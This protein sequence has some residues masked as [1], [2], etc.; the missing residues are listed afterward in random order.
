MSGSSKFAVCLI[1]LI[2][3][4]CETNVGGSEPDVDAQADSSDAAS[5]LDTVAACGTTALAPPSVR[6]GGGFAV[7]IDVERLAAAVTFRVAERRSFVQSRLTF[8]LGQASGFPVFDLRQTPVALQ[9]DGETLETNLLERVDFASTDTGGV[10]VLNRALDSCSRHELLV[11]YDLDSGSDGNALPHWAQGVFWTSAF[12][13]LIPGMYIERW[14]PAGLIHDNFEFEMEVMVEGGDDHTFLAN[15]PI[16]TLRFNHWRAR[17]GA[18]DSST[19]LW[20]LS[21]SQHIQRWPDAS[22]AVDLYY[23]AGLFGSE[24]EDWLAIAHEAFGDFTVRFGVHAG[25]EVPYL[26]IVDPFG[27]PSDGMEYANGAVVGRPTRDILRH[28]IL[29]A[30]LGRSL[31]P[32][33]HI[34]SWWD[35]GAA[36]FFSADESANLAVTQEPLDPFDPDAVPIASSDAWV[37]NSPFTAYT[38]G[39][40]VFATVVGLLGRD[41]VERALREMVES[42]PNGHITHH[43]LRE[44]FASIGERDTI[45]AL[46]ANWVIPQG[47]T[48]VHGTCR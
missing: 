22:G 43:D 30:W 8:S 33:R 44:A 16:E 17:W 10:L 14:F 21:R 45:E 11:E 42:C 15:A 36:T 20:Y 32:A 18:A 28:E 24:Q 2:A 29:H 48:S 5:L 34:D 25:T 23:A 46:F 40:R 39:S 38:T 7:P 13:D 19:P 6:H 1:S 4:A 9:L 12:S 3:G 31:L 35:E 26:L 41:Q 37:R 47:D 27:Q